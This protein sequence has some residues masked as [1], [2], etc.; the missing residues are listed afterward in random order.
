[1]KTKEDKALFAAYLNMAA[2][3]VC[4]VLDE[5]ALSLDLKGSKNKIITTDA[6]NCHNCQ[7]IQEKYIDK[8]TVDKKV[9]LKARLLTHF[10]FLKAVHSRFQFHNDD[11]KSYNTRGRQIDTE[12]VDILCNDDINNIAKTLRQFFIVLVYYR[13]M[14]S[15]LMYNKGKKN[16]DAEIA[17]TAFDLDRT[18][19]VSCIK[20]K[21]RLGLGNDLGFIQDDRVE[22]ETM[23]YI[24]RN[25][26][27][28]TKTKSITPNFTS[29][30]CLFTKNGYFMSKMSLVF[31]AS[32]FIEKKYS[33]ILYAHVDEFYTLSGGNVIHKESERRFLRELYSCHTI[34]MPKKNFSSEYDSSKL[35]LDMLNEISKCPE[36]LDDC[37]SKEDRAKFDTETADIIEGMEDDLLKELK[38]DQKKA[39]YDVANQCF[40]DKQ[41]LYKAMPQAIREKYFTTQQG[42]M[43]RYDDRFPQLAM[44]WFDQTEKFDRLR[45]QVIYGKYHQIFEKAVNGKKHCVDGVD[46]ERWI[47]RKL[48]EYGRIQEIERIRNDQSWKGYPKLKK[49]DEDGTLSVSEQE[50]WIT[51][52]APQYMIERNNIALKL[53][54][55][56]YAPALDYEKKNAQ[57]DFWMSVYDLPSMVFYQYLLDNHAEHAK[58]CKSIETLLEYTY[59]RQY[60]NLFADLTGLQSS[61]DVPYGRPLAAKFEAEYGELGIKWKDIPSKIKDYIYPVE[62]RDCIRDKDNN[63]ITDANGKT[64]GNQPRTTFAEYVQSVIEKEKRRSDSLLRRYEKLTDHSTLKGKDA[65][66]AKVLRPGELASFLSEDIVYLLEYVNPYTVNR[67]HPQP[68]APTGLNFEIMQKMLATFS[69]I[70]Q[71]PMIKQMFD[72][73]HIVAGCSSDKDSC[74]HPFLSKVL[75]RKPN[76]VIEFYKAYI[77][78]RKDYF[79]RLWD[80]VKEELSKDKPRL[81]QTMFHQ[82]K[83]KWEDKDDEYYKRLGR[84]YLYQVVETEDDQKEERQQPIMLPNGIFADEIREIMI[85]LL[86]NNGVPE[87]DKALALLCDKTKPANVTIMVE[88]YHKYIAKDEAQKF[89]AFDR[90]YDLF[91]ELNKGVQKSKLSYGYNATTHKFDRPKF[92]DLSAYI[93]NRFKPKA[94]ES[95]EEQEQRR[96]NNQTHFKKLF[97][98]YQQNERALN[99]VSVQDMLLF[100][101]SK[102]ILKLEGG[103]YKLKDVMP[104][105][106]TGILSQH[107][108]YT[109]P[110][111][112]GISIKWN[113]LKI[114]DYSRTFK[115]SRD[116]RLAKM[117]ALR[118]HR[119]ASMSEIDA[120][121]VEREFEKFDLCRCKIFDKI[122]DFEEKVRDKNFP[123][124]VSELTRA[125]LVDFKCI[126]KTLVANYPGNENMANCLAKMSELRD[127]F[128]H[129]DYVVED[130]YDIFAIVQEKYVVDDNGKYVTDAEGN[131]VYKTFAEM[132]YEAFDMYQMLVV[133]M[134]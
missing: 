8:L 6:Q 9:A 69:H 58:G 64:I 2:N 72:D 93:A 59:Q 65:K 109:L 60:R 94:G 91:T 53:M 87:D 27:K 75:K 114:K 106:S 95:P 70:L 15:H 5:I 73:L 113:E 123:K 45:F 41:A 110:V 128:S 25:G 79:N 132:M 78:M 66:T 105:A 47:E 1:M 14:S 13:N 108:P 103:K 82:F 35:G 111:G 129:N 12:E 38:G 101:I 71:Y 50:P 67:E 37:L 89:Y 43:R 134:L 126:V 30:H 74:R 40:I 16:A 34:R 32:L 120:A 29:P 23:Q 104:N 90:S 76:N 116:N 97:N 77:D 81:R 11:R 17:N 96:A 44:R 121:T 88:I 133:N 21:E 49:A 117:L 3:N 83:K 28:K 92:S 18:F 119:D 107:I 22:K 52:F 68:D 48:I 112:N 26:R 19:L 131:K 118:K 10:P 62:N 125:G 115:M 24:A 86:K 61:S 33:T 130:M 63:P 20:I 80:K 122:F 56:N 55:K 54:P 42:E 57:P 51:D 31:L 124:I 85:N 84:G 46:H 36:E 98:R 39:F 4:I 102:Q 7:F 100:Y 99:R 127:C